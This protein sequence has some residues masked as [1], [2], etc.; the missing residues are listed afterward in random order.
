MEPKHVQVERGV[1]WIG[2][3]WKL[4]AKNP[5]MWLVLTVLLVVVFV[6]LA[7]LPFGGFVLTL[8]VPAL[9]A[10]LLYGAAELDAGRTLE[11]THLFQGFRDPAK[12]NALIV[13]G[14]VALAAGIASALISAAVMGVGMMTMDM[15]DPAYGMMNLG[16]R[17]LIALLLA[18]TVHLAATVLLYFAVPLVMF[19]AVPA[20]AA[21]Q[22]SVR[23]CLRNILPLFVFSLIYTVLAVIASLPFGLGWLVLLPWSVGMFYCS[24]E[25][26]YPVA[27]AGAQP[28]ASV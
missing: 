19:R 17:A 14:V 4:F 13:L 3:G 23:A 7:F 1:A 8:F 5:G 6:L 28:T 18:L 15:G 16:P 27:P 12:R 22:A 25:D 20:A 26:I 11:L 10:G 9:A 24:Y 2:C 21:M